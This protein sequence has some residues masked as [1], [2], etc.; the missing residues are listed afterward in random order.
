MR[1]CLSLVLAVVTSVSCQPRTFNTESGVT[2]AGGTEVR[3]PNDAVARSTVALVD[4][5]GAA[6]CTGTL[7]S[8]TVVVTAAHCIT[9]AD[10]AL[11]VFVSFGIKATGATV[12]A[13]NSRRISRFAVHPD[14]RPGDQPPPG[15]SYKARDVALLKLER[16]APAGFVP[17]PVIDRDLGAASEPVPIVLAGYGLT[18]DRL[19]ENGEMENAND[20]GT[21]RKVSLKTMDSKEWSSKSGLIQYEGPNG[22]GSCRGDSGGPMY[23]NGPNGL[24]VAG[25]TMGGGEC[26]T[27]GVENNGHY[28]NLFELKGWMTCVAG[29]AQGTDNGSWNPASC[30]P[31]G[32][33]C[34][35]MKVRAGGAGFF[36]AGRGGVRFRSDGTLAAGTQLQVDMWMGEWVRVSSEQVG[37]AFLPLERLEPAGNCEPAAEGTQVKVVQNTV[38]KALAAPSTSLPDGHKCAIAAGTVLDV[39][40]VRHPLFPEVTGNH[41]MATLKAPRAGCSV[42][43]G[44]LYADHVEPQGL[45]P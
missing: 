7:V 40:A 23:F 39:H 8:P 26:G 34:R 4:G 6:F 30:P 45:M 10:M 9:G 29:V 31:L 5:K 15:P 27:A 25:A 1:H 43:T 35:K 21:L 18:W 38:F 44:F 33:A 42:V 2:I 41:L 11:P 12:D 19:G 28:T 3:D 32:K 16:E 17:V 13:P 22:K 37:V 14:Y 24:A 36:A 20:T